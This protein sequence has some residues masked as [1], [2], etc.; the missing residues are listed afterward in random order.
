MMGLPQAPQPPRIPPPPPVPAV[1][2]KVQ[3]DSL[4]E[5]MSRLS[6]QGGN[7]WVVSMTSEYMRQAQG[8]EKRRTN[9]RMMHPNDPMLQTRFDQERLQL[10]RQT[11]EQIQFYSKPPGSST[12]D[13]RDNTN[14][15]TAESSAQD[16]QDNAT[17][18]NEDTENK[19]DDR[20]DEGEAPNATTTTRRFSWKATDVLETWYV[21]HLSR[22]YPGSD[23]KELAKKAGVTEKQAKK[24]LD[25]RRTRDNNTRPRQAARPHTASYHPYRQ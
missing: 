1:P 24:W 23:V 2:V 20:E 3:H 10:I 6:R 14:T 16:N 9:S 22:P 15:G 17:G 18:D 25:N 5:E 4:L 12:R 19:D 7:M 21:Q 11:R 8:I 13:N